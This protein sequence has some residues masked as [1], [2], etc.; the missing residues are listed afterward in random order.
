MR[1]ILIGCEYAGARTL[2]NAIGEWA[3]AN[4]GARIGFHQH[5]KYPHIAH[6][7]LSEEEQQQMLA[8]SPR[9]KELIQ[10]NNLEYHLQPSF[11]RDA[12]H[13][14]IGFYIEEAIYAPLYFGYGTPRPTS[15]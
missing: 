2:A 10:R 5:W 6:S 12:D 3:N 13:N 14:M 8:I 9:M 11:Y 7:E 15:G 1:L 4:M